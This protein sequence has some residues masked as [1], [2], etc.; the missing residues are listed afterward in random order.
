MSFWYGF[1]KTL[2]VRPATKWWL[3]VKIE[4]LEN[5]PAD[6]CVLAANHLDAGDTFTLPSLVGPQ[7][8]FPAKRELF[9][10]K[11]FKRRVVAWFL[12]AVGQA[13][14]DRTGGKTSA[15][16]LGSVAEVLASGGVVGIF[17]EGTRSPDGRLYKGHTGVARL[18]LGHRK[19]VVPVGVINT[20]L[21]KSKI[22]IPT[23]KGARIIIG[24]PRDFTDWAGQGNDQRV[25]RWVTNEVMAEIQALTGQEY[26]DVYASRVKK[27]DLKGKATTAFELTRPNEGQPTPPKTAE[28]GPGA[29]AQ[30]D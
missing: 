21:V 1:F 22:G 20:R 8:T 13:P 2:L 3:R 25:L 23:M 5:I 11:G 7:V 14:I 10:G 16:G 27:G 17:P 4:G 18:T 12:R 30:E 24:K 15:A 26:V 29:P 28:L 6:G 9:E 19:P